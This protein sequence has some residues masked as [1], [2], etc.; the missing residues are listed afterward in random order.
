MSKRRII[1]IITV[2]VAMVLLPVIPVSAGELVLE[3]EDTAMQFGVGALT[4]DD[5]GEI[6]DPEPEPTD[7][8]DQENTL[9]GKGAQFVEGDF[10]YT[11]NGNGTVTLAGFSDTCKDNYCPVIPAVAGGKSVTA[12]A[13][14]AFHNEN[15]QGI[16][17]PDS[18]KVIGNGAFY[19]CCIKGKIVIPDAVEVI[20]EKAFYDSTKYSNGVTLIL[21]RKVKKIGASAFE[22]NNL[23]GD[24][25][26]P[27][28]VETIND[29]AFALIG[30]RVERN[31]GGKLTLGNR[32][33]TIGDH[34]FENC[35]FS[36]NL[37][38]P[39]S[40]ETIGESAF[41]VKYDRDERTIGKLTFGKKVRKIGKSAF[42][43]RKFK[44]DL[45]LPKNLKKLEDSVFRDCEFS[46]RLTVPKGITSI[47]DYAFFGCHFKG[48]LTIPDTVV[49]IGSE[50]FSNKFFNTHENF[51]G[52][53]KLGK[54]VK[55]IGEKAFYHCNFKGDL[56]L[57]GSVKKLKGY[58][59]AYC[60][61]NGTLTIPK[62]ITDGSET[63]FYKLTMV[64]KIV[65]KKKFAFRAEIFME[66]SRE[67]FVSSKGKKIGYNGKLPK[68][69]YT[70]RTIKPTSVMIVIILLFDMICLLLQMCSKLV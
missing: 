67:T 53:L 57:P 65:N 15:V 26:I 58:T 25:K 52:K 10:K 35:T 16:T 61:F 39:D 37:N 64:R 8:P 48:D 21:G 46:G 42:M 56:K 29:R 44:G 28:S 36:G 70:R 19:G 50:A 45:R 18:I 23:V 63:D 1:T 6:T 34:A 3:E 55:T 4:E 41:F 43:G 49:T 13:D 33:R 20:G 14:N 38:I 59:F 2:M 40:V 30:D 24:L 54:K 32:V 47:R 9:D 22:E 62:S 51:T 27:D 12:I 11:D 7:D 31:F 68:G 69:T 17:L 5:S 66:T 60:T